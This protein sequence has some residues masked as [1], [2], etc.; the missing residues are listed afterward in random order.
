L[1]YGNEE[2]FSPACPGTLRRDRAGDRR[3]QPK[4]LS[5]SGELAG[6]Y[7]VAGQVNA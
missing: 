5:G 6:A 4:E 2:A 1:I 3:A 7:G